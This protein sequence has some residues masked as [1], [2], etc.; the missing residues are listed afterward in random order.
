MTSAES[1]LK[2][3]K[4]TLK[5]INMSFH[6]K[7]ETVNVLKDINIS[8]AEGEF[9]C[10]VGPS[11]CGKSTLLRIIA[12]L[13]N[14][15]SG[16][17]FIEGKPIDGPGADRAMVFQED[18][19][20]PWLTVEKN[21]EYGLKIKGYSKEKRE[22]IVN[23]F[24]NIVGLNNRNLKN[25]FP[26]E[27]SGGMRKRVDMARAFA[28]DP[29]VLLMDEPFGMLDAIT[30]ENLQ[31]ETL[32]LW[33]DT[34]KT[35]CFVT[36]DLEEA[37]FLADRIVFLESDPGKVYNFY[38][39]KFPRPRDVSLK[40]SPEFQQMRRELIDVMNCLITKGG[41]KHEKE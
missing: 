30:K 2:K 15:T 40:M 23:H 38:T 25:Y 5:N 21:V 26:K 19:V 7:K 28:N 29:E 9:V 41:A 14:P 32:K 36:H 8:I 27:L 35:I 18:S 3:D 4:I 13:L 12:G 39:P 22:E 10:F 34:K 31:I 11:G 20:F 16:E 33:E 24:L 6:S 1:T 37:I 17:V